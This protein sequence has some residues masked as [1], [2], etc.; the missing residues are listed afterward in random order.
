M[1]EVAME[2]DKRL[3]GVEGRR[4]VRLANSL[5]GHLSSMGLVSSTI[6]R[7]RFNSR[8]VGI[9]LTLEDNPDEL[10]YMGQVR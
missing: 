1:P 7:N 2:I 5:G 8:D 10:L 9:V 3:Q 6:M 4:Q